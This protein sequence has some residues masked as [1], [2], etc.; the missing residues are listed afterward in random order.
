VKQHRFLIYRQEKFVPTNFVLVTAETSDDIQ[1][2]E[3]LQDAVIKAVETWL[4]A[5]KDASGLYSYA[6]DDMNVGDLAGHEK[7]ICTHSDGKILD[8][9]FEQLDDARHDWVYDTSL[10]GEIEE[11]EESEEPE[12]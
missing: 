12:C 7:E 1:T 4:A 10:C 9:M 3:Q 8:L 11:L 2:T 5:T 6:G